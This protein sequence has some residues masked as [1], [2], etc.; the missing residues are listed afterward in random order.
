MFALLFI[1]CI[2]IGYLLGGIPTSYLI[3]KYWGKVNLLKQGESHVSATAVYRELG[4]RPFFIVF[5]V[6][7]L[8]GMLAIY[9][10]QVLTGNI[11]VAMVTAVAA[12]AGHCWSVY[13]RFRGGLGALIIIGILFYTGILFSRTH[14]PWEF[15]LGGIIALVTM[16]TIKK[17][18]LSTVLWL[19][20]ISASLFIEL[21]AFNEGTLAM[22]L[23]PL[24]L[25]SV[26]FIKQR[27]SHRQ[28]DVYKNDLSS[29]FRRLKSTGP[30]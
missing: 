17:S 30:K 23:L 15:A 19:V 29:D 14:I 28:G 27:L 10:S 8:K 13:I 11:W 26:Q 25:L 7:V 21:F 5:V 12:V 2:I 22:A 16:L 18:T 4:W 9:V 3:G 20:V 24:M 1:A 6:D